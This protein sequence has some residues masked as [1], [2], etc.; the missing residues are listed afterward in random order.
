MPDSNS[1][2]EIFTL[3]LPPELW[4]QILSHLPLHVLWETAR[5][6]CMTWNRIAKVI[7][8]LV[9]YRGSICEVSTLVNGIDGFRHYEGDSL[10]PLQGNT[11]N[12][13]LSFSSPNYGLFQRKDG[14]EKLV[15]LRQGTNVNEWTSFQSPQNMWP[16]IIKY[17]SPRGQNL[18]LDYHAQFSPTVDHDRVFTKETEET[19]IAVRR[20]DWRIRVRQNSASSGPEDR[21]LVA[22]SIPLWQLVQLCLLGSMFEDNTAEIP[23]GKDSGDGKSETHSYYVW[24]HD[25][26]ETG[27]E[28]HHGCEPWLRV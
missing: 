18:R 16:S 22:L 4:T 6:V 15:W 27:L 7:A 9:L 3:A 25:E 10:L 20:A 26:A 19:N 23:M 21:G 17:L 1:S 13:D 14:D 2:G 24:K 8:R 28:D 12:I 5:P 11:D